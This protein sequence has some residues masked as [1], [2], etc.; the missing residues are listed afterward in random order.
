MDRYV[1]KARRGSKISIVEES[2]GNAK[3]TV[4]V[5]GN[6]KL[7]LDQASSG[8]LTLEAAGN[9]ITLDSQGITIQGTSKISMTAGQI[10]MKAGTVDVTTA[11]ASFSV[12]VKASVV[13][14]HLGDR[15]PPTR[16]ERGTY[17]R[18]ASGPAPRAHLRRQR[19][20]R[21]PPP[22]PGRSRWRSG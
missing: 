2:E 5:P 21:P 1:V 9:K 17:G 10:E 11:V 13:Q 15:A 3:I 16:R 7:T 19:A 4:S 12:M 8:S 14:S 18:R 20:A 6:V 22:R